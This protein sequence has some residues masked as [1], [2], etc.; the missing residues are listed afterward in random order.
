MNAN[1]EQEAN[2][3]VLAALSKPDAPVVALPFSVKDPYMGQGCHPDIVERIWDQ[4]GKVF[5]TDARCLVYGTPALVDPETGIVVA[6]GYGTAYC[7]RIPV[8]S[9]PEAIKL[10][11][12]ISMKW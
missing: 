9:V 7:V 11:A 8:A 12:R 3:Q 6:V 2:A 10:G 4:I 5:L 1:L